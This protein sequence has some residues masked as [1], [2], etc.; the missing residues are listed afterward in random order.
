MSF[1]G[2]SIAMQ[3]VAYLADI[4]SGIIFLAREPARYH[5]SDFDFTAYMIITFGKPTQ[6]C[7]QILGNACL[8]G[9][10]VFSARTAD[11]STGYEWITG[12]IT[13]VRREHILPKSLAVAR[14]GFIAWKWFT[15]GTKSVAVVLGNHPCSVGPSRY[16]ADSRIKRS[17]SPRATGCKAEDA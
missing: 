12:P 13:T 7:I 2:K 17:L 5:S 8:P 14:V 3:R 9:P 11:R 1:S 16:A 10:A 4:I 6:R 15:E